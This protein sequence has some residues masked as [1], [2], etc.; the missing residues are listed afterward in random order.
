MIIVNASHAEE[1][2][3]NSPPGWRF[4]LLV[5]QRFW[6]VTTSNHDRITCGSAING[7]H[8]LAGELPNGLG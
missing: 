7:E 5:M 8:A 3:E 2:G 1:H 4:I 6:D